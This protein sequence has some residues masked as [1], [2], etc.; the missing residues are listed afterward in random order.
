MP[1]FNERVL[2]TTQDELLP[3]VQ[4][5]ILRSNLLTSRLILG[6]SR[7]WTGETLRRPVKV[8]K[9]QTGGAFSG[10]ALFDTSAVNNTVRMSWN[11]TGFYQNITIPGIEKAVNATTARVIDMVSVALDSASQDMMDSIGDIVYGTADGTGDEFTGLRHIIL[12]SGTIGGQSRSTFSTL[13]A[14]VT[15][16]SGTVT[17]AKIS[18]LISDVS[19]GGNT[20]QR[21]TYMVCDETVFDLI[22]TLFLPNIRNQY[23]IMPASGPMLKESVN[24]GEGQNGFSALMY[25]GIPIVADEK[26]TSQTLFAVNDQTDNL[27]FYTLKSP[28][29][30]SISLTSETIQGGPYDQGEESA[31]PGA[32]QW[33]GFKVPTNQFG[34]VGQIIL[35]GNMVSFNPVRQGRLTGI[36]SA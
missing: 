9:S 16:S 23:G 13:N 36:T 14:T 34:E 29:L 11:P 24:G 35:L 28:D 8:S 26:A 6:Q 32:M 1:A 5:T 17:L 22:E 7:V 19:L 10:L 20:S 2:S 3:A 18:T 4:D 30:K 27:S 25:R 33:T 15:D 21:P 12:D 31:Q